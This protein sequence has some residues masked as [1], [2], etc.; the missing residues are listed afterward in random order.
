MLDGYLPSRPDL[1][2]AMLNCG[3][4]LSPHIGTLAD[5][6]VSPPELRSTVYG[7]KEALIYMP[8]SHSYHVTDQRE[9][10]AD[11]RVRSHQPSQLIP[12][13]TYIYAA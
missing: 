7:A 13:P 10:F 9:R 1:T 8:G 11:L 5:R 12:P 6:V 3:V 2:D 4:E